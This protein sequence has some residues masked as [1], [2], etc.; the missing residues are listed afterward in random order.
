MSKV[1]LAVEQF[2]IE[3]YVEEFVGAVI[4][5][6]NWGQELRMHCPFCPSHDPDIKG[7][8]YVNTEKKTVFCQRCRYGYGKDTVQFI[9]DLENISRLG[10][11]NR[12][13]ESINQ[14]FGTLDDLVDKLVE[15][16]AQVI[17]EDEIVEIAL[18]VGSVRLFSG[19]RGV[20]L[21][22]AEKYVLNRGLTNKQ[23]KCHPFYFGGKGKYQ[24][25]LIIPVFFEGKLV[26]WVARDLSGNAQA[27]YL[28]AP[29]SDQSCWL[30]N[31]DFACQFE[32]V[33]VV[34]GVF[35]VFG[36]ERAN[37]PV[38]ASFGKGI[39]DAQVALL[40]T[41]EE[42]TFLYD[43]E[44]EAI[45]EAYNAADK[46]FGPKVKVGVLA[47]VDPG[48]ATIGMLKLIINNAPL[49]NSPEGLQQFFN[50]VI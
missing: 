33:V 12:L 18:P 50:C 15:E 28:A 14:S 8:F 23:L 48:E 45:T 4:Q 22:R 25:R 19:K 1:K 36:V 40:N 11:I 30:Y 17:L 44:V 38:V 46:L 26:H 5:H 21:R 3:A 42:V 43:P 35:D 31:W 13:I 16:G 32:S 6:V 41:F 49:S 9:A 47:S 34:E 37:F 7:K 20:M 39:S 24:N 10:A 27:K 2:D 29:D